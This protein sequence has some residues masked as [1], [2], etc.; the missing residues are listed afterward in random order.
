MQILLFKVFCDLVDTASFSKAASLNGVTQSA[1]S[2]QVKALEDRFGVRLVERGKK[3]FSLTREGL[4]FLEAS[5]EILRTYNGLD[6]R[7]AELRETV[8]GHLRVAAVLSV[9][10][11]EL[12]AFVRQFQ[13]EFSQVDLTVDYVRCS[14][15]YAR[16]LEGEADVGFV[17]YPSPRRG[18][19]VEE[20]WRHRMVLIVAPGHRLAGRNRLTLADLEGEKF[21]NFTADLPTRKAV[22][23]I[24]R[25]AKVRVRARMEFDN[26]ETVKRTVE[27]EN[28]IALVPESSLAVERRS[29]ALVALEIDSPDLWRPVGVVTR[30][31]RTGPPAQRHFLAML[32]AATGPARAA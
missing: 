2:Q 6:E 11:H 23:R 31:N 28:G 21:I 15:V 14:E 16:V 3:H 4:A 29:G 17:A 25:G 1:V 5:R 12:P 7:I 30:K 20:V 32:R 27:L 8:E 19:E 9:G 26:I 13:R 18:V 24:L 10:L 22:D